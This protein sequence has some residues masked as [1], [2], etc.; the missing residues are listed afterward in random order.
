[1]NGNGDSAA[2]WEDIYRTKDWSALSWHARTPSRSLDLVMG[3]GVGAAAS[4]IDVGGGD[5]QLVDAL[6]ER[7]LAVTVL[8][9]SPK[10]LALSKERLGSRANDVTWLQGDVTRIALPAN[11]YDLWHDRAVFHFLTEEADRARYIEAAASVLKRGGMAVIG[12]FALDGPTR[13]SGLDVVQYSPESLAAAFG[14]AFH[15]VHG[16]SDVHLTP[17]GTEQRFTFVVLRREE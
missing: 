6:L 7:G 4:V 13:C 1:M 16:I 10:A 2:H 17:W 3:T 9:L 11:H 12:T 5:S 14:P 8:D 15:L